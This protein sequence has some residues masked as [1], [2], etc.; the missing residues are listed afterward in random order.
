MNIHRLSLFFTP[1][2]FRW[3]IPLMAMQTRYFSPILLT[4]FLVQIKLTL[5]TAT[6]K[7]V[8]ATVLEKLGTGNDDL[9]AAK[10]KR[11]LDLLDNSVEAQK[12]RKLENQ[13]SV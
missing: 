7:P 10:R 4:P 9:E 11:K 1:I 12:M 5:K 13:V 2:S 8:N 6:G 3:K